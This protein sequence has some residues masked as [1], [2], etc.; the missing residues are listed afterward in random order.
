[1]HACFCTCTRTRWLPGECTASAAL[2]P[3]QPRACC[4][5]LPIVRLAGIHAVDAAK[6]WLHPAA[7][8]RPTRGSKQKQLEATEFAWTWGWSAAPADD[9]RYFFPAHDGVPGSEPPNPSTTAQTDDIGGC[10]QFSS[11]W[12]GRSVPNAALFLRR[13]AEEQDEDD[14]DEM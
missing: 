9:G 8:Q 3:C 12:R 11:S 5:H 1:M 7:D 14:D 6:A 2:S 13:R 10:G 4:V